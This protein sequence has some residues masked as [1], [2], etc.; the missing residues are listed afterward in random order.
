[1]SLDLSGFVKTETEIVL[2]TN[3]FIFT[4]LTMADMAAFRVYVQKKR[5][6]RNAEHRDRLLEIG[7]KIGNI[8]PIELLKL[9]DVT[10]TEQEFEKE[11]ETIEGI[12]YLTYLS[13]KH[14]QS[15]ISVA[16][17]MEIITISSLE[18][19]VN[20]MFPKMPDTGIKKKLKDQT[21]LKQ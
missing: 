21:K 10:V 8:D 9:T 12:G 1:M 15:D 20:A 7:G 4:E 18:D 2:G 14:K 16:D 19:V 11:T 6:K 17:A 13:L 5:E 3:K